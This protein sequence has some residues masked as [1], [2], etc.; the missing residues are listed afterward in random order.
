ME[1]LESLLVVPKLDPECN[2]QCLR[3]DLPKWTLMSSRLRYIR[4]VLARPLLRRIPHRIPHTVLFFDMIVSRSSGLNLFLGLYSIVYSVV[5]PT[6]H[7]P[8]PSNNT[9]SDQIS[10]NITHLPNNLTLPSSTK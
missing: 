3:S 7:L 5:P 6:S 10:Q 9:R 8:P 4:W 1:L 2:L